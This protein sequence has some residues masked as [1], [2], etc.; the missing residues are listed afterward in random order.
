VSL[1]ETKLGMQ[2]CRLMLRRIATEPAT[3]DML[4]A[5]LMIASLAA[6]LLIAPVLLSHF[7]FAVPENAFQSMSFRSSAASMVLLVGLATKL[8]A[9][10]AFHIAVVKHHVKFDGA[11]S[12]HIIL[13]RGCRHLDL[14]I[15]HLRLTRQSGSLHLG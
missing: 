1:T 8:M 3:I 12:Q 5:Y 11:A 4:R 15:L 9:R 13:T 2:P 10:R 6:T 14:V 7:L